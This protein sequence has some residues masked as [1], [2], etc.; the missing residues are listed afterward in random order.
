MFSCVESKLYLLKEISYHSSLS[1]LCEFLFTIHLSL[2]IK[3]LKYHIKQIYM[4][5]CC[6]IMLLYMS[7]SIDYSTVKYLN[8]R[9]L[10]LF[11]CRKFRMEMNWTEN[12][13][14]KMERK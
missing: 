9:S 12:S 5:V 3:K 13:K 4:Q 7:I 2:N 6:I 1:C 14:S 8:K 10:G 11:G